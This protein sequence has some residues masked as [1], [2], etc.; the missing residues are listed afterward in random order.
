M[1]TVYT[2]VFWDFSDANAAMTSVKSACCDMLCSMIMSAKQISLSCDMV[3]RF[4]VFRS[5][6][7]ENDLQSSYADHQG[8]IDA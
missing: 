4:G 5:F 8:E 2:G 7:Q 6:R 1:V 3:D